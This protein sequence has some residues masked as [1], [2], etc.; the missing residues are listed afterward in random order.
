MRDS[1]EEYDDQA[2]TVNDLD[3]KYNEYEDNSRNRGQRLE[4]IKEKVRFVLLFYFSIF[5]EIKAK[6]NPGYYSF[7]SILL[8]LKFLK[9]SQKYLIYFIIF[10]C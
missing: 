7:I 3:T 2:K 1:E 5:I 4:E 8:L 6:I 9:V 10:F